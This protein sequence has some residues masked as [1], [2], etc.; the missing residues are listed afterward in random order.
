MFQKPNKK[1]VL[2]RRTL[3]TVVMGLFTVATIM[4]GGFVMLK[5]PKVYAAGTNNTVNFQARLQMKA[6]NIAADGKYNIQFKLYDASSAGNLL[7]TETYYDSNGTTAG[8]DNRVQATNGYLSVHLGS[9]NAF[10]TTINWDQDLYMTMNVGG[11]DQTATP[12]YDGEMDPRLRLTGVPYAF[13][14]GQ[15]AQYSA[16]TG[17]TSTL[18]ILQPTVGNQVFQLA[19]QGTAG[20]YTLCIQ[21]STSCGFAPD[22]GGSGYIQNT[23]SPQTADFNI[24]GT[25]T[26]GTSL[27]TP[28]VDSEDG[29]TLDVGTAGALTINIGGRTN[30]TI[31]LNSQVSISGSLTTGQ[32]KRVDISGSLNS[33]FTGSQ[34][35]INNEITFNP[36]GATLGNLYGFTSLPS[37]AGS[38]INVDNMAGGV[39]RIDTD[40]TYLGQLD[41]A[42]GLVISSPNING[43]NKINNYYGIDI[44]A[45]N[46]NSGGDI[47]DNINNVQLN[48]Q[49]SSAT[50]LSGATVNN[51]GVK[52]VQPSGSGSGTTNNY[53]LYIAGTGGGTSNWSLYNASLNSSYF[54]GNLLI[55]NTMNPNNYKLNLTGK[56]NAS[57]GYAVGGVDGAS[58]LSCG[59]GEVLTHVVINGG[60]VMSAGGC[61]NYAATLQDAYDNSTSPASILLADAK[62]FVITAADTATD[63]NVLINLQCTTSCGGNGRFAVQNAGTD[64]FT[65]TS[66]STVVIGN[67]TDNITFDSTGGYTLSGLA[68]KTM[69]IDLYPEYA[70]AVLDAGTGSNNTGTMTSGVDLTTRTTY[71]KWT[72]TAATNQSYDIVVQVP[73]PS[74]FAGWQATGIFIKY[75]TSDTTN[76]TIKL[77]TRDSNG[78][79]DCNFAT[80]TGATANT[81]TYNGNACPFTSSDYLPGG[82]MYLR[83]RMQSP[84]NGDVRVGQIQMKYY[85]NN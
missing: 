12:S 75:Y 80:I 8:N 53:G 61:D 15:L 16:A 37:L 17:F 68:R 36:S 69:N 18:S 42:R 79:V 55:G 73:I 28:L 4:Y 25:G 60:L 33:S 52:I 24:T 66:N 27:T 72:T 40:S 84:Q 71:Y 57:N 81:W 70:G 26:I 77:E 62:D 59:V 7:W 34:Y 63:P 1:R 85:A 51:Y 74:N 56:I 13:R 39:F 76:G 30:S 35:G 47:G 67:A 6:G 9:L 3:T 44:G 41:T 2:F 38:S 49:G 31:N 5:P 58:L 54:A 14:A 46:L 20:T 45:P 11:T 65:V 78:V 21:N 22:T 10:P 19:D 32:N 23:T 43:T 50:A 83:I 48:I 29:G 64:F 82:S